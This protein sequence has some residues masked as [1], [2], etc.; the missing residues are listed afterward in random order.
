MRGNQ[1]CTLT[2][3]LE[4]SNIPLVVS[5]HNI[6]WPWIYADC[7]QKHIFGA[8]VAL[9]SLET[10]YLIEAFGN[11]YVWEGPSV[12]EMLPDMDWKIVGARDK[13]LIS[14][15][16]RQVLIPKSTSRWSI[17]SVAERVVPGLHPLK[18]WN[19]FKMTT[20]VPKNCLSRVHNSPIY[21][22]KAAI[23]ILDPEETK[24]LGGVD[25]TY[26]WTNFIHWQTFLLL[27]LLLSIQAELWQE[28]ELI[29]YLTYVL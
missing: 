27:P 24:V 23:W 10:Q 6:I 12:S 18:A 13:L 20:R 11:I 8:S 15:I 14:S 19:C 17:H 28:T 3:E 29:W 9:F 4:D 5:H 22:C 25:L 1:M 2:H 7:C 26:W 16:S 21:H